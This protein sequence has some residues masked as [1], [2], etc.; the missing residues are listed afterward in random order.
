M[1]KSYQKEE[2]YG[3]LDHG[4]A[5]LVDQSITLMFDEKQR[6]RKRFHDYSYLVFPIAKAYE[7]FLKKFLYDAGLVDEKLFTDKHFRIGRSLNPEL[8]EKYRD[9][10]WVYEIVEDMCKRHGVADLAGLMWGAWREARNMLFHY[11][12]PDHERFLSFE[13]AKERIDKVKMVMK[14]VVESGMV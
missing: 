4:M 6:E 8:P 13:G 11:F 9:D 1:D 14:K 10:D 12:F 2:W 7:G 5:D 3:Y